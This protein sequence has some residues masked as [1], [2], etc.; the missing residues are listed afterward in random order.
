M[1]EDIVNPHP[2]IYSSIEEIEHYEN[3][4]MY[5]AINELFEHICEKIEKELKVYF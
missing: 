4:Y 2:E 5:Y 3:L 1:C